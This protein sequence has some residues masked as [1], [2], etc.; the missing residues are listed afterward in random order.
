MIKTRHI[1]RAFICKIL[2]TEISFK[3]YPFNLEFHFGLSKPWFCLTDIHSFGFRFWR[4]PSGAE[5]CSFNSGSGSYRLFV[6]KFIQFSWCHLTCFLGLGSY[7]PGVHSLWSLGLCHL[8]PERVSC[9]CRAW[10]RSSRSL[11]R[12]L[13]RRVTNWCRRL[14]CYLDQHHPHRLIAGLDCRSSESTCS[15]WETICRCQSFDHPLPGA[16]CLDSTTSCRYLWYVSRCGDTMLA[17][18]WCH[19]FWSTGPCSEWR[20]YRFQL[21]LGWST[22]DRHCSTWSLWLKH[23]GRWGSSG[24]ALTSETRWAL[25]NH[26]EQCSQEVSLWRPIWCFRWYCCVLAKF[27]KEVCCLSYQCST[28]IYPG[29]LQQP[30]GDRSTR[31]CQWSDLLVETHRAVLSVLYWGSI[32]KHL[33]RLHLRQPMCHSCSSRSGWESFEPWIDLQASLASSTP[34]R[35][36][37]TLTWEVARRCLTTVWMKYSGHHWLSAVL[38]THLLRWY[39]EATSMELLR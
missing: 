3:I 4:L 12:Q 17:F 19:K 8:V 35:C 23:R 9:A 21:S 38:L 25:E 2:S 32:S 37:H 22:K 15:L 10:L 30:A 13:F 6:E 5:T 1:L 18:C 14:P 26:P 34:E 39:V 33:F 36:C 31:L 28:S 20:W 24:T 27:S 16:S 7:S 29:H 11:P